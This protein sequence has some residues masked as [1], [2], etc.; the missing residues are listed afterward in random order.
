MINRRTA[1]AQI[2]IMF[3][4]SISVQIT[5]AILGQVLN[6]GESFPVSSEQTYLLGEL[7][8]II[9]PSTDTPGAKNSGV[10]DFI[11]R[12][13]RDCYSLAD[14]QFFYTGLEIL[15]KICIDKHGRSFVELEHKE[16]INFLNIINEIERIFYI[17]AL[18]KAFN[19]PGFFKQLRELTVIG[20][21]TSETGATLA[22]EYLPIPG[23]FE[24]DVLIKKG[25]RAWAISV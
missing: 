13:M 9:I 11:I 20:Y 3:G 7:A 1:L 4:G 17:K 19:I 22:L 6:K 5:A 10:T 16:K 2:S 18:N 23:R 25:Q 15:N 12:V 21:F 24:G 14:Q 8:E